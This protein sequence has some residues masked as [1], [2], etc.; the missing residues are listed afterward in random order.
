MFAVAST[1]VAF[2]SPASAAGVQRVEAERL[3]VAHASG[4][5]VRDA[6]ASGRRALVLVGARSARAR[7]RVRASSRLTVVVRA[8]SCG[9]APR[10]VV[11][12]D[13]ARLV[14]TSVTAR[15]WARVAATATIDAGAHPITLRLANPHRSSRCRRGLRVDRLVFGAPPAAVGGGG[16]GGGAT[17]QP[18]AAARWIP[19]PRT[20]WQW[21]LTTPVDQSVD[22]QMY[23]VDLF[24]NPATVVAALHAAGRHVVC[25]I[26]VG[27][28]EPG[29]PDSGSF[30]A[31]VIGNELPDWPGEH[32]LDVRRLDVLGPILGAR[33]DLCK[34]K[35][36]DAVEADNVDAY[37]NDSGFP[38]TGD[39]QLRF[40]RFLADAAHQRGLSIG[41][42]NDLEQVSALQPAFDWAINEQ[43][44]QYSE[45]SSL[46]PFV[47][48]GKAV[49][50]VE[51]S[52]STASFCP[53][54]QAGGI[55][56][57]R[58]NLSL[59]AVRQPCW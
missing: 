53:Q 15:R 9:G 23:D 12:I 20:T 10:L 50:E 56:A 58:K 30:P 35:G 41:L 52:L 36:F 38:L 17:P 26:D 28:Y 6:S 44:F 39:D 8:D 31:A 5:V 7:V 34:Q 59:D 33:F 40:N 4:H 22:A 51:Y 43:C 57:M 16:G 49:F 29:R 42:K 18:P 27:T 48:A 19:G 54:A 11:T 21:Q 1:F 47:Q 24:D 3:H 37:A 46:Q 2:C 45:C 32:W 14:S 25:Y 55:M 13:G